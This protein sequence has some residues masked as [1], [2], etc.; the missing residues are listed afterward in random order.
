MASGADG[1]W[2]DKSKPTYSTV[3]YM[4]DSDFELSLSVDES[5]S[6]SNEASLP[7]IMIYSSSRKAPLQGELDP[8]QIQTPSKLP[9]GSSETLA[10]FE[11]PKTPENKPVSQLAMEA[12]GSGLH[13]MSQGVISP[14]KSHD[15][16]KRSVDEG[17]RLASKVRKM[18]SRIKEKTERDNKVHN[19]NVH[20][21]NFQLI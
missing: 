15:S 12:Q 18:S 1:Q 8:T 11:V 2:T 3:T 4:S 21:D 9:P 17:R 6:S 16:L 20:V 14:L 19:G 10:T 7:E 13:T 5:S